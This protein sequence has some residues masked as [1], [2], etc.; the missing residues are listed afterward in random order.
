MFRAKTILSITNDKNEIT[1]L[2]KTVKSKFI[3]LLQVKK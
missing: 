2:T 1:R 3:N